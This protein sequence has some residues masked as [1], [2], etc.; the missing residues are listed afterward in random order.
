MS[1][2]RKPKEIN[3]AEARLAAERG[4]H[5]ERLARDEALA[6]AFRQVEDAY[7]DA[8]K[9]AGPLDIEIRERAWVATKLLDDLRGQILATVRNG[10]AAQKLIEKALH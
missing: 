4:A 6:L 3:E 10:Q 8:W 7:M 2:L 5:A 1:F 9:N